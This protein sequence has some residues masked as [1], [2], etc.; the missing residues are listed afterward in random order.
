M[1]GEW[2]SRLNCQS[3]SGVV[4]QRLFTIWGLLSMTSLICKPAKPL[5]RRFAV[6]AAIAVLMSWAISPVWSEQPTVPVLPVLN[7]DA[8]SPGD[9][10]PTRS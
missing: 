4:S 7:A 9:M 8:A 6:V 10:R 2:T 5:A 3:Y 1:H